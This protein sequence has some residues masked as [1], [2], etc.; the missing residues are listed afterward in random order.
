MYHHADFW[1]SDHS[2]FW[3]HNS[4]PFKT[5]SSIALFDTGKLTIYVY[6]DNLILIPHFFLYSA[7]HRGIMRSCYHQECDSVSNPKLKMKQGI[8]FLSLTA[9]ALVLLVANMS[10]GGF[11][12]LSSSKFV[13]C[14]SYE[15][16]NPR[17]R[18][19][20]SKLKKGKFF[21]L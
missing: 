15:I 21:T 1:R 2:R 7:H 20:F 5:I 14:V 17:K 16:R 13:F 9:Q 3:F 6:L 8:E 19:R 10:G 11:M 18:I 12:N 4:P